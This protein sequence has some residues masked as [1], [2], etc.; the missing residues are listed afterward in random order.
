MIHQAIYIPTLDHHLLCTVQFIVAGVYIN[1]CPKFLTNFPQDN[2][3]CI[4]AKYDYGARTVL[5]LALQG[6]TSVLNIVKITESEWTRGD[7][8]QILLT[9]KELHWEP[10]SSIF[11]EQE[12]ACTD[13]IGDLF[14]I[15]Y[16]SLLRVPISRDT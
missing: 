4:I 6:V 8:P 12:H 5:T 7:P 2:S 1:D 3:H 9:D 10:N 14:T 15:S 11:D 13:V 16:V